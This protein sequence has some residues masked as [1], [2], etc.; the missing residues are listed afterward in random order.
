MQGPLSSS[1]VPP[2]TAAGG[3]LVLA[4]TWYRRHR[5]ALVLVGL[6]I[7]IPELLTGSTRVASLLNPVADLFLLGLYGGGVLVIREVTLRW[8]RGWAP[9]LLLGGAYAIVEEGLGTKTFFDWAEIGR[10][11]FGP[12]THWAGVNWVWVGELT[13]FHA[14][15]SIALPI[16]LTG[17][18]FPTVRRV[19]FLS[20]RGVAWTFGAYLVTVTAMF[21]LFVRS[22]TLSPTLLLACLVSILGLALAAWQIPADWLRPR[23][24][25]PVLSPRAAFWLGAA[26]VWGFFV[27]FLGLPGRFQDPF[28]TVAVGWAYSLA[29]LWIVRAR[30]GERRH[31]SQV[32]YLC[33]GLLTFFV[34][35]A[36]LEEFL[37]DLFAFL[38]IGAVL[39]LMVHLFRMYRPADAAPRIPAGA[40]A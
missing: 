39:Y 35:F 22:F 17:L 28:L 9:V 30:F 33:L 8:N 36:T 7:L 27:I 6:S 26:F 16:A 18:L 25:E 12:Y 3:R 13:V 10:P 5:P 21:F 32:A 40:A 14:V 15:F 4:R 34:A 11:D 19:R 37:G 38:A 1:P 24:L 23:T 2:T 20:D 31:D 29:C